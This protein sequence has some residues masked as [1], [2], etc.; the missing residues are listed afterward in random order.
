MIPDAKISRAVE[1]VT[2]FVAGG[3]YLGRNWEKHKKFKIPQ[4][5]LITFYNAIPKEVWVQSAINLRAQID[6]IES[7]CPGLFPEDK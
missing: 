7:I 6:E 2:Q 1:L 3:G 5:R 4:D